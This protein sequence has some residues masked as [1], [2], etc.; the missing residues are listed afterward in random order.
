MSREVLTGNDVG[1]IQKELQEAAKWRQQM[2]SVAG[3]EQIPTIEKDDYKDRL[4][5][6][7]PADIIAAYLALRSFVDLV[8]NKAA[9]STVYIVVFVTVLVVTIPWQRK[10]AKIRKW[11]QVWIGVGA[12]VVWAIS[13]GEPFTAKL[14]GH[15]Y[16]AAYGAMLL[17]LYTFLIPLF[18]AKK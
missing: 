17:V 11:Q 7:I 18:E 4:M 14:L 9:V 12:F 10:V 1:L 13:L 16:E 3:T 8:Q 15:W 6:Y 5:K 2:G